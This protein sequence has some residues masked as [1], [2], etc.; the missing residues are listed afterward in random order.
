MQGRPMRGFFW[1]DPA[2]CDG[3]ALTRWLA[4]A[5]AYVGGMPAKAAKKRK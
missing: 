3:E 4:L 1:V 2:A 5:Q